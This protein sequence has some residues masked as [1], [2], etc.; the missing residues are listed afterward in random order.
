[1]DIHY[2]DNDIEH[3]IDSL[4]YPTA[5]K[6]VRTIGLLERFGN[7]LGLPHSKSIGHGLFELRTRGIHEVRL[8]Y[9]FHNGA[10]ILLGFVKKSNAIPQRILREAIRKKKM[11]DSI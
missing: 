9:T 11:L 6:V 7:R 8:F 4:D 2:F 1:M 10:V 5:A 3:F